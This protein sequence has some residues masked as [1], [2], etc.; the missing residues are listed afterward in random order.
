MVA[1]WVCLCTF[2]S[3]ACWLLSAGA[4]S[5]A[6]ITILSGGAAKAGLSDAVP[7]FEQ[8]SGDKAVVDYLPMWPLLKALG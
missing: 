2:L 8:A 1:L 3:C 5:A 6:D 4:S 7:L